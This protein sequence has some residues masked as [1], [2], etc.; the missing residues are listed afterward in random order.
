MNPQGPLF[1]YEVGQNT[2]LDKDGNWW[3][4]FNLQVADACVTLQSIDSMVMGYTSVPSR[5]TVPPSWYG[6]VTSL[7]RNSMVT[8]QEKIYCWNEEDGK[9]DFML[10]FFPHVLSMVDDQPLPAATYTLYDANEIIV[11]P[12]ASLQEAA[13]NGIDLP[14][15]EYQIVVSASMFVDLTVCVT[16]DAAKDRRKHQTF[17]LVPADLKA[18]AVLRWHNTPRE[19]DVYVLPVGTGVMWKDVNGLFADCPHIGPQNPV[20]EQG[21]SVIEMERVSGAH[22]DAMPADSEGEAFGPQSVT[23]QGAA[24]GQYRIYVQAPPLGNQLPVMEGSAQLPCEDKVYVDIYLNSVYHATHEFNAGYTKWWYVGYF[25]QP[26]G[27]MM[28][29]QAESRVVTYDPVDCISFPLAAVLFSVKTAGEYTSQTDFSDLKY[30]VTRVDYAAEQACQGR[31]LCGHTC[32][33]MFQKV[34]VEMCYKTLSQVAQV[35][36]A[37]CSPTYPTGTTGASSVSHFCPLV[38]KHQPC[39]HHNTVASGFVGPDSVP[40]PGGSCC[41]EWDEEDPDDVYCVD[42]N[43]VWDQTPVQALYLPRAYYFVV[44]ERSGFV[45]HLQTL[46][47]PHAASSMHVRFYICVLILY[48]YMYITYYMC[49]CVFCDVYMRMCEYNTYICMSAYI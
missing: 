25:L 21:Q 36:Q 44:F 11:A 38:C 14:P 30:T 26:E 31:E 13:E 15:G 10:R 41:L 39:S 19:L 20:L 6:P 2:W 24:P 23:L 3:H 40:C 9:F 47:V 17:W 45:T 5:T 49:T 37:S 8:E 32:E 33:L 34:G 48:I 28:Q 12:G 1:Y 16:M 43:E 35:V 7:S 42:T 27:A 4:V 29:W 22:P 46:S 18:R